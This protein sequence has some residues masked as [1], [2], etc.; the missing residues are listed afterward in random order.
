MGVVTS[1]WKSPQPLLF[2]LGF[3]P[4]EQILIEEAKGKKK[5]GGQKCRKGWVTSLSL[6]VQFHHFGVFI[7]SVLFQFLL[8]L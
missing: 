5:K 1:T 6:N 7:A 2:S 4:K 3:H 8:G